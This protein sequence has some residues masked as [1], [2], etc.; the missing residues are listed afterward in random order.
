MKK[1][2]FFILSLF[3]LMQIYGQKKPLDTKALSLWQVI[4]QEKISNDGKIA[5]VYSEPYRG[6]SKLIITSTQG[7][8]YYEFVGGYNPKLS[9]DNNFIAF[10]LKPSYEH[11][12]KLKIQGKKEDD[13]PKDSAFVFWI[14]DKTISAY[15]S[16]KSIIVP[17]NEGTVLALMRFYSDKKNKLKIY[18]FIVIFSKE[19]F[20]QI[21]SVS[22]AIFSDKGNR[23]AYIKVH[24]DSLQKNYSILTYDLTVRKI[25]KIASFRGDACKISLSSDGTMLAYLGSNDTTE[26]KNY[27]LYIYDLKNDKQV[28]VINNLTY[29]IPE[30]M[31]VSKN[32]K[33][34]FNKDLTYLFFGVSKHKK[35]NNK[36]TIPDDEKVKLNLWSWTDTLLVSEQLA[37]LDKDEKFTYLTVYNIKKDKIILLQK[38]RYSTFKVDKKLNN[39]Y[40]LEKDPTPYLRQQSW[41]YPW[42]AD[43]Y[44]IDLSDGT[45]TKIA[46]KV[47]IGYLSPDSKYFVYYDH[48][49]SA[50]YSYI[51]S[52]NKT[53]NLTSNIDLPFYQEDSDIPSPAPPY[54]FGGFATKSK[55]CF[56]YDKYDIWAFDPSGKEKPFNLTTGYGRKNKIVFRIIDLN[57]ENNFVNQEDILLKA[58]N[59]KNKYSGFY[60]IKDF[61]PNTSFTELIMSSNYYSTPRKAR[62]AKI[63][64]WQKSSTKEYPDLWSS[65]EKFVETIRL[66]NFVEQQK[67]Y[68]WADV[69]LVKWITTDGNIEEG[70]LFKPE[71]L[72]TSKKYPMIVYYYELYSDYLNRYFMPRPS[73]SIINPIHYASNGYIVFIPNIRY[74]IGFPGMSAYNYVISGTLSLLQ[75]YSWIDKDYIGLQGQSWGGYQTAFIITQTNL[76][77]A[78]MAG[79]PVS[80]MTSAYGGIRWKTGKSRMFQY[81]KTQSRI[82]KNLWDALPLYLYN[83]PVFYASN[84]TTPLLIMHND[85]DGAVPWYQ[86]IELFLALRRLNKP[87]WLLNYNG[88][89]HNLEEKS[90]ACI[91]LTDKMM[92][93]FDHYLK[94]KPMPNWMKNGQPTNKL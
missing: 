51:K 35:S 22:E 70:L 56:I 33:I 4:K 91:D 77:A 63:L 82:G 16:I 38:N 36:D 42:W 61:K 78:A 19:E 90:P 31:T 58:F 21:D 45:E 72:D 30:N 49:D 15:D 65:D 11:V 20:E 34:Y 64:I 9:P 75:R 18:R 48:K 94:E 74:K 52:K 10:L 79:A 59:K 6:D 43:Y 57:K 46:E 69:E 17:E 73:R 54:G 27:S 84:I 88:Q 81:E 66:T 68:I 28:K 26:N 23:L 5:V 53:I 24:G 2:V 89:P 29:D 83:S 92:Q 37:N 40:I 1:F 3:V 55:L 50:W 32:G 13:L 80:N 8:F 87:V 7:K 41:D 85:N 47:A 39:R 67:P 25:K 14:K 60:S 62:D 76:F 12:R 93:F 44:L 71:N 86:G